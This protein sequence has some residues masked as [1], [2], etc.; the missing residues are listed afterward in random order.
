MLIPNLGSG[1]P[2]REPR[3]KRPADGKALADTSRVLVKPLRVTREQMSRPNY[4]LEQTTPE[5]G[6]AGD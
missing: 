5:K 4:L 2:K 6:G 1:S 3:L